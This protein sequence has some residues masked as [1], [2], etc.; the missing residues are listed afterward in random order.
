MLK[1]VHIV[2]IC[3][4]ATSAL[5]SAFHKKGWKVTGS[6]KGFF[7]PASTQLE[8]LGIKFYAGW[9]PEKM[10]AEG[11]PDLVVIPTASGSQNPETLYVEEHKIPRASYT[12][13]FR[14]YFIRENSIVC[15]GTWG[16]TSSTALLSFI[17]THA[18]LDPAYMFGGISLSHE[19]SAQIT[20]SKWSVFEGD[21]YKSGPNDPTA[22]FFYYKPTHLLFTAVS[23]DH[24]DLYPTEDDYF[25]AFEKLVNGI[26]ENGLILAN[27][28]N[29]GIARLLCDAKINCRLVRYGKVLSA[30]YHYDS[31]VESKDGLTFTI[32]HNKDSYQI[33]SP[34]LGE[35]QAENITGCF[36]MA[37]EIG[38]PAEKIIEA[39]REFKGMKRRLEKRYEGDIT[40]ID[41]IAHSPEKAASV[42][43]T[44]R[45]IY[46][47]KI[48]A[49]FEPNIGGRQREA[50]QKYD[51]AFKDADEVIIPRLTKLKV[52]EDGS[53]KPLEGY[54][55]TQVISKTHPKAS[56][57]DDDEKLV[58]RL[59]GIAKKDDVIV[60][61]GS[62]G[63]RGMIERSGADIA[64]H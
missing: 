40:V 23:W 39:I 43:A 7:P 9:H 28:D 11:T 41:D 42:L 19:M 54:E 3:G 8:K 59:A 13:V 53:K 48:Y 51:H 36:A 62:H 32:I 31:V 18:G 14:D 58:N 64:G 52:G 27:A 35:F 26:P 20:D 46:S 29:N 16:K 44:L 38:I 60:F 6:D 57:V 55:L 61:L 50:V 12:E 63:F 30:D 17:L 24:A 56:Y 4:V 15:A 45:K 2:G 49:V 5:A 33:T 10:I 37:R 21:E 47:G 25:K 1:H 34:M 22:K